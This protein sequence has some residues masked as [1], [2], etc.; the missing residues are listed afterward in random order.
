MITHSADSEK[1]Q[2]KCTVCD[3]WLKNQRCLKS[4]MQLHANIDFVCS[5]CEYITKKEKLLKNHIITK[6]SS[7]RPFSCEDCGKTF[8]VKRALTIH[9][10]QN[11]SETSKTGKTCEFC[12][13][14]FASSTNYY[15]HRKNLHS[16]ELQQI[17]DQKREE[18]K[19]KRIKIGL[20]N[21]TLAT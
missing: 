2:L 12:N 18:E 19:L 21:P 1:L 15:T 3:K 9:K 11:H 16:V 13:R 17:L 14:N 4:H 6:H 8:K 7:E 5:I 10:A 20:E